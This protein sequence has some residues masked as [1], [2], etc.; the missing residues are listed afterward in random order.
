[1][2]VVI[3]VLYMYDMYLQPENNPKKCTLKMFINNFTA[4]SL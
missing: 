2:Y 4:L 3:Y 1:M